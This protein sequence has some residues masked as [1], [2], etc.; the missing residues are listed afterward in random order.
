M[1]KTAFIE[2]QSSDPVIRA[3]AQR[4]TRILNDATISRM[5]REVLVCKAQDD[6]RRRQENVQRR[7]TAKAT[8]EK[9]RRDPLEAR[10]KEL[11]AQKV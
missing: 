11:Q 6:L 3:I 1:S 9:V 5:R 7:Q 4:V 10:R 2:S 8:T